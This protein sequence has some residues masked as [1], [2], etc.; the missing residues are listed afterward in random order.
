MTLIENDRFDPPVEPSG[1]KVHRVARA[2]I[3]ALPMFSGAAL[4]VLNLLVGDPYNKRR[5]QWLHELSDA[6]NG[7]SADIERLERNSRKEG[8]VLSAILQ[9]TDVALKTGDEDIHRCLVQI[10][11][12]AL[13]DSDP[14]EELIAV[15]LATLRQLTSS[16]LKLLNLIVSRKRYEHGLELNQYEAN[17]FEEVEQSGLSKAIPVT[18]LLNDLVSFHLI[19][20]PP[21]SPWSSGGTNYCTMKPTDF[22]LGLVSYIESI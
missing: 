4:E 22:A 20:S 21:G 13:Q 6:I 17:F 18:R 15:Y 5:T 16:H 9:S 11:V 7:L 3:G 10:V 8:A 1:D 2:A 14:N 12:H 19:Y